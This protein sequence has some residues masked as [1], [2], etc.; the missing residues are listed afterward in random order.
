MLDYK[1][2]LFKVISGRMFKVG[3]I[4]VVEIVLKESEVLKMKGM[5]FMVKK[6]VDFGLDGWDGV[7]FGVEFDIVKVEGVNYFMFMVSGLICCEEYEDG[8]LVNE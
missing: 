2:V 4:W 8:M 7:L 1:V 3:L 5:Y 6:R